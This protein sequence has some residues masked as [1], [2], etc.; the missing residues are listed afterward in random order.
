MNNKEV[1]LSV[2]NLKISFRTD[3][4]KV[5]AVR[6]I[7]FDLYKG[8]TLA[9]VGESGSGKSVTS[10]AILGILANNAIKEGGEILYDGQDLMKISEEEFCKI[11]G[12]KIAM[13]FQD[14]L[15]SLN[16][17]MRV[18]K[19]MTEAM[20]INGRLNQKNCR[21]DFNG[22]LAELNRC[23]NSSFGDDNIARDH[24]KRMC[25]NFDKFEY[26]HLE[27]ENAYVAAKEAAS[28][29]VDIIDDVLFHIE[30]NALS[31]LQAEIK[32]IVARANKSVNAYVV[33]SRADELKA[34]I[35]TLK[36][37][38]ASSFGVKLKNAVAPVFNSNYQYVDKTDYA[39]VA[40]SLGKVRDILSE[41]TAYPEPNF[42]SMG[43]FMTFAE[44]P[45]PDMP[46]DELNAYLHEYL[47]NN[48]MLEFIRTA[49]Q[50]IIYSAN[51]STELKKE[52]LKVIEDKL[53]VFDPDAKLDRKSAVAAARAIVEAVE[54]AINKLDTVKDNIAYTFRSSIKAA[55]ETYFGGIVRNKKEEKRF[56]RQSDSYERKAASGK[57]PSWKVADK[58]LVDL[59]AV[60]GD[61]R[62]LIL[63]IKDR[64]ERDIANAA[65]VDFDAKAVDMIDY[66]K[67][68]ASG[69]AHKVTQAMAKARALKLMAEV[70]IPEPRKRYRQYPFEFSGGMRQRIVIAIALSASPDILICDEPTTALDVTIQSQILEL[71]NKVKTERK[72]SVIFITH[73]LG[74]VANMADR[75][76]VMYA[77]KIVEI[78]T[79]DDIFYAPAH[80]YTWALL[81]SMPDLDTKEKLEAIPGTPPNMIYPPRGDAFAERNKYAMQIDFEEQPPMFAISETHSAATWLLHPN[82]PKIDPPKIITDRIARMKKA[83]NTA[84]S[85]TEKLDDL[86]GTTDA[87]T[88]TEKTKKAAK[89]RK[90]D[91]A[92]SESDVVS[93]DAKDGGVIADAD[94]ETVAAADKPDKSVKS[95][96]AAKSETEKK[97]ALKKPPAR[98]TAPKTAAKSAPKNS[99]GAA[100]KPN[101][102]A[103]TSTAKKSGTAKNGKKEG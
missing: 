15:S 78:G 93:L 28:E 82:A 72:L 50:G 19:Q 102:S 100:K 30:K 41:A 17:I 6:N 70:G 66:L 47:D 26:K 80:P 43:Y 69:V 44:R 20:I 23:M 59:S 4:G 67:L 31:G 13:I 81:S 21:K 11:R 85:V 49:K 91:I 55:I 87:V 86:D 68:K 90:D 1:K 96:K 3:G 94:D 76:A 84:E 77:G 54:A 79:S 7:N 8:E 25:R 10:R 27:L 92:E 98:K 89:R 51:R 12:D 39:S 73:D 64:F 29:G 9:I 62:T 83:M 34:E 48:F 16:P 103:K 75:V 56:A 46:I 101:A 65:T 2:K 36:K 99:S 24:N 61:I 18:G 33:N 52:A 35:E 71:I 95:A 53:T 14:P 32:E 42:F 22:M 5:Q 58:S 37:L 74:V 97:P 57:T 45:L 63:R 60:C 88:K 38:I 40:I